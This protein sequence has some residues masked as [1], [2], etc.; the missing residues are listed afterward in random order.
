[1][2]D[3]QLDAI[4]LDLAR[5]DALLWPALLGLVTGILGGGLIVVFRLVVEGTQAAMLPEHGENFEGLPA[6]LRLILPLIGAAAI[7]LLFVRFAQGQYVLGVVRV[8]ERL[9]YHQGYLTARGLVLQFLGAAIAIISG[10]SVGREGP[11]VHLGAASGSL[12]AQRLRLPNNSIRQLVACGTAAGIAASFNTPLAAVIF[13]LEVLAL[14]YRIASFIPIMLAAVSANAVSVAVFGSIPLFGVP[15]FSLHA[16]SD[17]V[18]VVTLGLVVGVLSAT[19]IGAIQRIAA[20][21]RG[22]DF[23]VRVGLA[24]IVA[25][26]CGALVPEVMGLGFDTLRDLLTGPLPWTFLI[27]LLLFKLLATAASAGLGIPGGTIGP[28]LFLGAVLGNLTGVLAA[29]LIA[30]DADL[31][32]FYALLGMG[33]MMGASFQA[34]LAA[35][36]AIVEL[37]HS[38]AAIGPGL[39]AIILAALVSKELF[40]QDSLFVTLLRANGLDYRAHPMI[41]LLRRSAVR[42]L[43]NRSLVCHESVVTRAQ[44]EELVAGGVQWVVVREV[45]RPPY[46]MSGLAVASA[47][48]SQPAAR[49]FDLRAIP[50]ERLD[51]APIT[52]QATLHEALELMRSRGIAAL[53]VTPTLAPDAPILGVLTAGQIEAA[54]RC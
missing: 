47:L 44:A 30:T 10:H 54:S 26:V 35:L 15:P 21:G 40:G 16:A 31:A 3:R 12:L 33:A 49:R 6:A 32:G 2:L 51:L 20:F 13:A 22:R 27:L 28:A 19:Y 45:G 42:S 9:E 18:P 52:M 36:T 14:E 1:M 4:R 43:M 7:G 41:Q 34:P 23:L 24:G 11:H 46:L 29:N 38:P 53:Y 8:M 5:P 48:S 39:L 50:G 17:L 25:G 37:T